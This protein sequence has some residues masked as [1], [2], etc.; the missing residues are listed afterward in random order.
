M[1]EV[2]KYHLPPARLI[3]N[4]PFP[5]L[6]YPGHLS[7]RISRNDTAVQ[8]CDLFASK[9]WTTQWIFRYGPTQEAH[10]HSQTHECMVVLHGKATIRFGAADGD[11][12]ACGIELPAEAGDVF[13]IPAGVAHKTHDT[14]RG[15]F[16]LLTPGDG[17]SV[18]R[19]DLQGIDGSVLTGFVMMGAYPVGGQW[20]FATGGENSGRY[21]D[22]WNVAK[23]KQ[24]PVLGTAS[25]GICELW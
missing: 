2:R 17:H 14:T 15:E 1:S 5:L 25:N 16:A 22:V 6:H 3:P 13:I 9:G 11:D 20:D 7:E 23:P 18:T 10:Y 24:D 21:E 4:S 8:I 12:E 19:E